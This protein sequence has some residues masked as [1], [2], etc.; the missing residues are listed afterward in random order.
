MKRH[1]LVGI[2]C[3]SHPDANY[4]MTRNTDTYFPNCSVGMKVKMW[5]SF[6]VFHRFNF[7]NQAKSWAFCFYFIS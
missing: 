6:V 3:E 4:H 5:L 7:T 2:G 1:Y